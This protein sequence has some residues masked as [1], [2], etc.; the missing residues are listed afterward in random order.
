MKRTACLF[1]AL[2]LLLAACSPAAQSSP[3]AEESAAPS[4]QPEPEP[5]SEPS[6]EPSVSAAPLYVHPLTGTATETDIS[7]LKPVAIMLND[8][9]AAQ[10]QQGVSQAD[11]I[12]EAPAEGG[13]TRMLAVYQDISAVEGIIGSVR[14]SRLYYIELALGHDAVYVH[15]GGSPEA[16]EAISAW[17]LTTVDGVNGPFS[18]AGVGLFWRDRERV[19]GHYYAVEHSLVTSGEVLTEILTQRGILGE[20]TEGY[21]YEMAFADDGTPADGQSAQ[22][23]TVPFSSYKNTVFRYDAA[24]GLYAAEQFG[25][26]YCDGNDG[27][28]VAVTNVLVLQAVCTVVDSAGRLTVDLSSGNGW[29]A[30]GGRLVPIT[31]EKGARD[32]QLRYYTADGQPLTLGRGKSYVCILPTGR[33]I[34]VE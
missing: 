4:V 8:L 1:A 19:E 26:A 29:Y 15:A 2:L 14:S 31:W 18:Y 33:E 12:Y 6:P 24:T 3:P 16:Y 34:T 30:C 13:I 20:H 28:Q 25:E 21:A 22:V 17:G 27:S 7:A 11:I 10:P 32:E 5:S 9:K 23:V